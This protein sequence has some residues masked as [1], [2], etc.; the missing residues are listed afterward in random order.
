MTKGRNKGTTIYRENGMEYVFNSPE[1]KCAVDAR[2]DDFH[3]INQRKTGG[4]SHVYR[5][6][7]SA[8]TPAT[9]QTFDNVKRWHLGKHGPSCIEDVRAMEKVLG[10]NLLLPYP[11]TRKTNIDWREADM[12]TAAFPAQ[13]NVQKYEEVRR[14]SARSVYGIVCDLIRA[15]QKLLYNYW[16]AGFPVIADPY[17][18]DDFPVY[19]DVQNDIRKY[20]FDLPR[21]LLEEIMRFVRDI[22]GSWDIHLEEAAADQGIYEHKERFDRWL[23]RTGRQEDFF[24]WCEFLNEYTL[25]NYDLLDEIFEDYI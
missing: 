7:A 24:E 20:G 8:I 6:L 25:N 22:Y 12:N 14:N 13:Q 23:G 19:S 10:C 1:F 18:P 17:V 21:E 15:Q 9:H 5:E 2:V 3:R 11:D 16:N 4:K